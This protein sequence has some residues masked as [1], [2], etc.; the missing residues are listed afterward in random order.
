MRQPAL[1][2]FAVRDFVVITGFCCLWLS[3]CI[4]EPPQRGSVD[5]GDSQPAA[6]DRIVATRSDAAAGWAGSDSCLECHAEIGHRYSQHPMAHSLRMIEDDIP[7]ERYDHAEFETPPGTIYAA[8]FAEGRSVHSER[9]VT[10]DGKEI[11]RQDLEMDIV[12]GSGVHGRSW[13]RNRN[14]RF[15]QSPLTWYAEDD[16]WA[17]SPGYDAEFHDRFERRVTHAC[18]SCHAGRAVP[19]VDDVDRFSA[20]LFTETRIGCERCHGPGEDH[21]ALHRAAHREPDT[22]DP[23][24]NP[25]AFQDARLDAVCNQCHLAGQRRVI[26]DGHSEFDFRPGMYLSDLWTIFVKTKGIREGAAG[27]VSHVEQMHVSRCYTQSSGQLSCISCHDPHENPAEEK[28]VD[29]YRSR[30]LSCHGE[31]GGQCSEQTQKRTAVQDSCMD[32]HMPQYPAADVHSAQTDHR[33]LTYPQQAFPKESTAQMSSPE[34]VLFEEPGVVSDVERQERAAGIYLSEIAY[35]GGHRPSAELALQKLQ[36][37]LS[38]NQTDQEA[39]L[40]LGRAHIQAGRVQLGAEMLERL[41]EINP[42]QEYALELLSSALHQAGQ[43]RRARN[44]YVQLLEVNPDKSR[45][46]GRYAHILG[47]LGEQAEGIRAAEK[48]LELDP[49]LIQAHQWLAEV[50]GERGDLIR[51]EKHKRQVE[52]LTP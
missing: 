44:A 12:T 23:I 41:L 37:V 11:Y 48:A 1:L 9:R 46:W 26:H 2:S 33:I 15:Y 31:D 6:V 43:L 10:A 34:L 52:L 45:H 8:A 38:R 24:V 47:R 22:A 16:S 51:S 30:C 40:S 28:R 20:P 50:H 36:Q 3:G 25:S 7:V 27:A 14:G 19:S 42:R 39:L 49:S 5:A 4:P 18:I 13:L 21:V 17:L 32:C 29:W 35:L